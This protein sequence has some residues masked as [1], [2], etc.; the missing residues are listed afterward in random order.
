[1]HQ[2]DS[3]SAGRRQNSPPHLGQIVV[4]RTVGRVVQVVEL[5]HG[6]EAS[7]QE[8]YVELRGDRLHVVRRHLRQEA[9]HRVAPA[10]EGARAP[11]LGQTRKGPLEGMAV[12]VGHSRHS[13]P[14]DPLAGAGGPPLGRALRGAL[15]S[16]RF[17]IP[18]PIHHDA[19]V[20]L[21]VALHQEPLEAPAAASAGR[22]GTSLHRIRIRRQGE[23]EASR[24]TSALGR[25]AAK[26]QEGWRAW[27]AASVGRGS[28]PASA[29]PR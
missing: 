18:P 5:P 16:D 10:P 7:L 6:G 15:L 19:D 29:W 13:P 8:L 1:M 28:G 20:A 12:K 17:D 4:G 24:T 2:A 14:G 9:V 3:G 27:G 25:G 21:P 22:R 26:A 11:P 23:H